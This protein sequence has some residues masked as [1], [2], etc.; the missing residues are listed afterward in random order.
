MGIG[1]AGLTAVLIPVALVNHFTPSPVGELVRDAGDSIK[2]E[3]EFALV[4]FREPN[5]VWEMRRV[6][7]GYGQFIPK[8][9]VGSFLDEPG[10]HAVLLAGET[11]AQ[12]YDSTIGGHAGWKIYSARGFNAAKGCFID[13]TLIV[14]P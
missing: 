11:W 3:T 14:K 10:P 7:K 6:M 8:S 2:P 12:L 1:F 4:D 9:E 13:L 5:A